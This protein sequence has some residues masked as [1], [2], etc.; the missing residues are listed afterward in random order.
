MKN[1]LVVSLLLGVMGLGMGMP[2]SASA[3]EAVQ[4]AKGGTIS[5]KITLKGEV[6][7]P[8]VFPLAL[9]PFGPFCGKNERIADGKGNILLRDV[10]VGSERGLKDVVVILEDIE[11][12][13]PFKPIV[14]EVVSRGCEFLPFV[15]VV[16]DGGSFVMRNEDPVIHNSQVYQAG[17][18]NVILN[19][20]VPVKSVKTHPLHFEPTRRI[21]QMICGMHEFMHTWGFA[22]ENP[23]YFVTDLDGRF[24]LRDIPPGTYELLA[25]HPRMKTLER[26][27]TV[28]P[29]GTVTVN[30]EYDSSK[31]ERAF[32]ETQKRF[33]IS[34]KGDVERGEDLYESEDDRED[35]D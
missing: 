34:P 33:R 12:G 13:K 6:P 20:P 4:V 30:L 8:R 3:Y 2:V 17:K 27:V 24:E 21:Y 11:R 31:V 28:G 16:Q 23:Y 5:G 1:F 10:E 26:E 25:W 7:D 18:G 19:V 29:E 15:S 14:A 9:Y 22:V 32:Y 35:E